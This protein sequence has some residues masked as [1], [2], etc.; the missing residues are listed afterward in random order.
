[1]ANRL[2]VDQAIDEYDIFI[3]EN[4]AS[5]IFMEKYKN[6]KGLIRII[7]S[8]Y[9]P[10]CFIQEYIKQN[11]SGINNLIDRYEQSGFIN[12]YLPTPKSPYT[13]LMKDKSNHFDPKD[14]L[15]FDKEYSSPIY[16]ILGKRTFVR[17]FC[18]N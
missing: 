12:K 13:G 16:N 5:T 17:A 18:I 6:Y 7:H 4:Y 8:N 10:K 11:D 15:Y 3:D 14:I 9:H 2:H 1:M